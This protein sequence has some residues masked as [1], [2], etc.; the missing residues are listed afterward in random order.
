LQNGKAE[1]N[2]AGIETHGVTP[3]AI[4]R[5]QLTSPGAKCK[6]RISTQCLPIH[7]N[8]FM[9]YNCEIISKPKERDCCVFCSYVRLPC[10]QI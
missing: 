4:D 7:S 5:K 8:I 6:S 1:I 3:R 2:S 10:R 9:I